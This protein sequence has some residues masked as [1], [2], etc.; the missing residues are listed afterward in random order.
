MKKE[1][2]NIQ[3]LKLSA[4]EERD[5]QNECCAGLYKRVTVVRPCIAQGVE[6]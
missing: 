1:L 3:Q 5:Q 6:F 4:Y 2:A